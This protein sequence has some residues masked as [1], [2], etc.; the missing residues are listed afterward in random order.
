MLVAQYSIRG[1][2]FHI[3][4]RTLGDYTLV[5]WPKFIKFPIIQYDYVQQRQILCMKYAKNAKNHIH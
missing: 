2:A 3:V 1:T 4:L 5:A